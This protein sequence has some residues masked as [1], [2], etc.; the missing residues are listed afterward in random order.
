MALKFYCV[1]CGFQILVEDYTGDKIICPQC[2][3]KTDQPYDFKLTKKQDYGESDDIIGQ[4]YYPTIRQA[5]WLAVQLLI[6][7][8]LV[9]IPLACI[10][11]LTEVNVS[12]NLI[13]ESASTL[14]V[15]AIILYIGFN[16]TN[17]PFT[18]VFSIRP[19]RYITLIPIFV[20]IAGLTILLSDVDNLVR[21]ILPAP[22][23]LMTIFAEL[24]QNPVRA[25]IVAVV[26]AP[27]TEEALCRGLILHGFLKNYSINKAVIASALIFMF[28]HLN[29]WQFAGAFLLGIVFALLVIKTKSL[30]PALFGHASA[31]FMPILMTGILGLNIRGFS[32]VEFGEVV[33]QPW[34]F[35]LIGLLIAAIGFFWLSRMLKIPST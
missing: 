17:E 19:F 34:W 3:M 12:G 31:N 33:L 16:K 28:M 27:L 2:G 1:N 13:V 6:L 18:E 22:V 11:T 9:F 24:Y 25:F 26:I 7:F 32:D 35:D 5:I 10:D 23:T 4:E 29:P 30:G 14:I 21:M 8:I 15:F 20:L